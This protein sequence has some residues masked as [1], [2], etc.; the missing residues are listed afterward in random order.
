MIQCQRVL[1]EL[2]LR[3]LLIQFELY[4]SL[5]NFIYAQN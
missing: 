4:Y 2:N 3:L 5:S 1:S